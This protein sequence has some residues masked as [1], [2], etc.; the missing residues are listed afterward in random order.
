MPTE[1]RGPAGPPHLRLVQENEHPPAPKIKDS[2]P[3]NARVDRL[4][5]AGQHRVVMTV[6]LRDGLP[7]CVGVEAP[8]LGEAARGI[9][10]A[11][12]LTLND[13]L[14]SGESEAEGAQLLAGL[15][16]NYLRQ[17]FAPKGKVTGHPSITHTSSVV[18]L[19]ARVILVN[20]FGRKDLVTCP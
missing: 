8:D 6:E 9:L 10:K 4:A 5:I 16:E 17:D 13:L 19:V 14:E 12:V 18:D 20:Y 15:L 3:L 1:N 2:I 11:L 7:V